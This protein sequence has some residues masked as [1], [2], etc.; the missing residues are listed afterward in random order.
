[1]G[2]RSLTTG[3]LT[4]EYVCMLEWGGSATIK[5]NNQQKSPLLVCSTIALHTHTP[6][7]RKYFGLLRFCNTIFALLDLVP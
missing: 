6:V 4:R 7:P 5:N 2:S 1:M 3:T